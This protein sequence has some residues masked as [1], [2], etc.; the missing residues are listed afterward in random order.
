MAAVS[1]LAMNKFISVV[2]L[3][4]VMSALSLL[5]I[6]CGCTKVIDVNRVENL[7]PN[8]G[9]AFGR[10]NV[11]VN[12]QDQNWGTAGYLQHLK[13]TSAGGQGEFRLFVQ[14]I[15]T[16]EIMLSQL[17]EDGSFAWGLPFGKYEILSFEWKWYEV[18]VYK[19]LRGQIH[20]QF[21]ISPTC[22]ICYLGT[23]IIDLD[24]EHSRHKNIQVLDEETE[25]TRKLQQISPGLSV[26]IGKQLVQVEK[27]L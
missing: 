24:K 25:A 11:K 15:T 22:R 20:A 26:N 27:P 14:S 2:R 9:I 19:Y 16:N 17:I 18:L 1:S 6:V 10:I 4:R 13:R 23:M 21:E 7:S 8:E 3:S 5:V 12:G